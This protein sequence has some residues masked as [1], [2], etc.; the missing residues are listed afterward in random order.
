[1]SQRSVITV[2]GSLGAASRGSLAGAKGRLRGTRR[3][4]K[5][6]ATGAAKEPK[7]PVGFQLASWRARSRRDRRC[8]AP[9]SRILVI[10]AVIALPPVVSP[11]D[12]SASAIPDSWR[13]PRRHQRLARTAL[14][15]LAAY[16]RQPPPPFS[17]DSISALLNYNSL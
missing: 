12:P 2:D 14:F 5:R 7:Q 1:L 6:V 15:H 8:I 17:G 10:A 13:P 3:G 11:G 4:A 16:L 9:T